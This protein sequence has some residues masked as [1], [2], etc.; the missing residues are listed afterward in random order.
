MPTNKKLVWDDDGSRLYEMGTD[1]GVIYPR[2]GQEY[3]EGVAWNGLTGVTESPSGGEET[4]LWADNIK[5]GS[6]RS[7]EEFGATIEA[8]TYPDEF[9]V[10]DGS[11]SPIAGMTIGQQT[12]VPFGFSYRTLIGNDTEGR[13][14]GYRI[15][16]LYG[17]TVTP[18][19][20]AYTTINDSPEAITFSWELTT[21]TVNVDGFSPTACLSFDSTKL[22]KE[23]LILL[24]AVLYGIDSD[25]A[26]EK[27][28]DNYTEYN[29]KPGPRLPMPDEIVTL[30]KG[31]KPIVKKVP[32]KITKVE[33]STGTLL[34]KA[35]STI[36]SGVS[37]SE[38]DPSVITATLT[39]EE[40]PWTQFDAS[41]NTGHFLA[42]KCTADNDAK[43]T[44]TI[45]GGTSN[46]CKDAG[47]G[48]WVFLIETTSQ[49]ITFTATKDAIADTQYIQATKKLSTSS[50]S[51]S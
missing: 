6:M 4:A 9:A 18:S 45:T 21:A 49:T 34:E 19:E 42:L 25:G 36:Q 3:K 38:A 27:L 22:K 30:L 44:A 33:P 15:H 13:D 24:E 17:C 48:N 7:A 46:K 8:Y 32:L 43:I 50:C 2:E 47:D 1:R 14:H 12:R 10:C 41:T 51:L 39:N 5:Y 20:K 16:L 11:A 40:S 31:A 28:G 29:K 37:L 35:V 26:E 23:Q